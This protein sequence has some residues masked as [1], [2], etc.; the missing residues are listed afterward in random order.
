MRLAKFQLHISY[1]NINY[2]TIL[3]SYVPQDKNNNSELESVVKLNKISQHLLPCTEQNDID[4]KLT[5]VLRKET[6]A[7][8]LVSLQWVGKVDMGGGEAKLRLCQE[9]A[10][11]H[12][13]TSKRAKIKQNNLPQLGKVKIQYIDTQRSLESKITLFCHLQHCKITSWS[14]LVQSAYLRDNF[15]CVTTLISGHKMQRVV[16]PPIF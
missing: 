6:F 2:K 16:S 1:F 3:Y 14:S 5:Q 4:N 15:K 11:N 12:L 9:W 10:L 8:Q 7:L 13:R